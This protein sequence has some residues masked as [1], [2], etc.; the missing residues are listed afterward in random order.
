M[1]SPK[2]FF[3][4]NKQERSGIFFLLAIIV[5]LQ[6]GYTCFLLIPSDAR[7]SALVVDDELQ[8]QIDSLKVLASKEVIVKRYPFNP[9]FITDYKGY[10]LGM[11]LEEIDRLH[12]FRKAGK[13]ANTAEDFQKVTGVSDSLLA[14]LSPYF[15][16]PEW[17]NKAKASEKYD[18]NSLVKSEVP[19][20]RSRLLNTDDPDAS[21]AR[22][23][24]TR[25]T[26]SAATG[27]GMLDL[28]S[29][30]ATDLRTINGIGEKLSA[31]ILKFRDRLGGFLVTE[32]LYDVYGLEPK[33]VE[34]AL[35]KFTIVE[36]PS[37]QKINI[38]TASAYEIGSLL[39]I[40]G[41]IAK[42]IVA[43]RD[44]IGPIKSFDELKNIEG[45]PTGKIPRIALYLSL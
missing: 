15:T 16:F 9:N 20:V 24:N 5:T 39:Y 45:F 18:R 7:P 38:N 3:R 27:E 6:L 41:K 29:A 12:A 31:R 22:I 32:Q 28:N 14:I 11:S 21:R 2:S 43:Y 34:R 42:G 4:F 40:Q 13:F 8:Q 36:R 33:V 35:Q 23:P 26:S 10:V 44:S 30:T 1:N 19:A 37:I 25:P 17:T